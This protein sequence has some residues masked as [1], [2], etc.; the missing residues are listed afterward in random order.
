MILTIPTDAN[1]RSPGNGARFVAMEMTSTDEIFE[2]R[3][4]NGYSDSQPL[5]IDTDGMESMT[6]YVGSLGIL[7]PVYLSIEKEWLVAMIF[8]QT[9]R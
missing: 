9:H 5:P 3:T 2:F 1:G 8:L 7:N 4:P 6:D